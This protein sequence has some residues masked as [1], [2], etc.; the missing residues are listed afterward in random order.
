MNSAGLLPCRSLQTIRKKLPCPGSQLLAPQRQGI[1]ESR[2]RLVVPGRSLK[3]ASAP[4]DMRW[5]AKGVTSENRPKRT[6]A[7]RLTASSDQC[8]CVLKPRR[9]RISWKVTS[10]RQRLTNQEIICLGSASSSLHGRAWVS[11]FPCGSRISIQRRA[12]A[13]KPVEYQMAVFE[14]TSTAR[15]AP[16]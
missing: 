11:N 13:G 8:R 1:G 4:S 6:G 14:T 7:V 12:T 9:R 2:V 15:S 5:C 16:P 3:T 10:I